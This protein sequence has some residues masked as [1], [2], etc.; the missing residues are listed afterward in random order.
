MTFIDLCHLQEE[1]LVYDLKKNLKFKKNL[2]VLNLEKS[3]GVFSRSSD[4]R[5]TLRNSNIQVGFFDLTIS[6]IRFIYML[7]TKA[8]VFKFLHR[9]ISM[10]SPT[11][12]LSTQKPL[13]SVMC[14]YIES[15]ILE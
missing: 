1:K 3:E 11:I 5:K 4:F 8:E 7:L 9:I 14:K 15:V 12:S 2:Q 6:I 10:E 13:S